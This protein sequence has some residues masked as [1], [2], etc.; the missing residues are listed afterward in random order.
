MT[1]NLVVQSGVGVCG[2]CRSRGCD[3]FLT[4]ATGVHNRDNC[5]IL[6]KSYE[7]D[8]VDARAIGVLNS[9][10]CPAARH[11]GWLQWWPEPGSE[12]T[13]EGKEAKCRCLQCGSGQ[14]QW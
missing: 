2:S 12:Y 11:Q 9:A 10:S 5:M 6:D 13:E 8:A 4:Q 3:V 14:L 1:P 7:G